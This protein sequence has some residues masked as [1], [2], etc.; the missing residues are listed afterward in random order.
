[1]HSAICIYGILAQEW[2]I[3]SNDEVGGLESY[4]FI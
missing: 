2:I 3:S 1:M 4:H